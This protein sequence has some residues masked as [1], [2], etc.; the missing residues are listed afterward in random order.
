MTGPIVIEGPAGSPLLGAAKDFNDVVGEC[1]GAGTQLILL[2][3]ENLPPQFFDVSSREA[4]ELLQKLRNYQ[5]RLAVV[6]DA[7]AA[8]ST[9]Q[10]LATAERR[11]N[12]F[13]VF[14]GREEALEWLV[15]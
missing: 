11:D 6:A 14:A 12:T 8:S 7:I 3:A 13:A 1:F 10:A 4:G 2:Y 9:F 15:G 5:L